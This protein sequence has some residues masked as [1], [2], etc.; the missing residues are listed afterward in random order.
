MSHLRQLSIRVLFV[1]LLTVS[2]SACG[3]TDNNNQE[4]EPHQEASNPVPELPKIEESLV[5][6]TVPENYP[7]GIP[8]PE[9]IGTDRLYH[10]EKTNDGNTVFFVTD[11]SVTDVYEFYSSALRNSDWTIT[12]SKQHNED[13]AYI[14]FQT[15]EQLLTLYATSNIPAIYPDSIAESGTFVR[16]MYNLKPQP[17]LF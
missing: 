11:Q 4:K 7:E 6:K 8:M 3:L 9:G 2:V 5:K 10:D 16:I 17:D 13:N 12:Q 1:I 14:N 15:G